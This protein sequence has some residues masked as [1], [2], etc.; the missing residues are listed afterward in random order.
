MSSREWNGLPADVRATIQQF[1]TS[2]PIKLSALAQALGVPVKASTLPPGIS[3]EIRPD[4]ENPGRYII[5]VNR[6]DPPSRQRFTVAHELGHFLLHRDQIGNGISDDVLYRSTLSD[7]REAEANRIAADIL[8]PEPLVEGA[9]KTAEVIRADEP[10]AYLAKRFGVS[11]AAMK[12]RLGI[13]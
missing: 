5:K 7:R 8:M 9:L 1:Q 2:Y 12:I 10:V 3:G 13:E 6:H 11:E 4:I